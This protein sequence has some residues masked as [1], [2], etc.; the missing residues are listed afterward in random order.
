MQL[1]AGSSKQFVE[2]AMQDRITEKLE[3]AFSQHFGR[4][5]ARSEARAWENSL[6]RMGIVLKDAGLLDHGVILEY[7]LGLTSRRLD[8]M[9]TGT[10]GNRRPSAV[11]IELKQWD[12][13]E[14]SDAKDNVFVLTRLGGS[15]REV[16]HPSSQVEGYQEFLE[17]NHA[18]FSA[19]RVSLA[20]CCYLHNLQYSAGNGLFDTRY[21]AILRSHPVFTRGQGI[22][23][24]N[25]LADRM[26]TGDGAGI[27][28]TV[29]EGGFKAS[30]KLL[31]HVKSMIEGKKEF[32]LLDEQK[33]VFNRV[34]R[35]A[36]IGS[37]RKGRVVILAKGGPGTGK[38]VIALNLV[39]ALSG[40]GLNTQYA[41]GSKAFTENLRDL[42][43]RKAGIQLKYFSDYMSAGKD[44]VDV[45][46]CDEAHRLWE[47]GNTRWTRKTERSDRPLVEHVIEAAKVTAFFIDDLQVVRPDEVGNSE[48]IRRAAK[49]LNAT[50]Y[51]FDLEAQF[52]VAGSE[53]FINWVDN[54]LGVRRA[55]DDAWDAEDFDFRIVDSV[56]ELEAMIR[57]KHGAG[58]KARLTAGF[59]WPWSYPDSDGHLIPDVRIG[60][61]TRPWNARS[62][63]KLAPGI[64]CTSLWATDPNG[65]DQVGC[66]YTAQGFEF[67]YVGVIFGEDLRYDP[68]SKTWVGDRT[69]SFDKMGARRAKIDQEFLDLVKN[70]YRVLLTRGM[71][72]CY[73]Y[74]MDEDTRNFFN[75][76][77]PRQT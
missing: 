25:F 38:S 54:T 24:G 39:A 6:L 51:E 62:G 33:A 64:P 48:L 44:V 40:A 50:V 46:V 75:S 59:C 4:E 15:T 60:D 1:Y 8:F 10:D 31:D 45:L 37:R 57:G 28:E 29:L 53:G 56:Q 43:G 67:D 19:G 34:L 71:K 3:Q 17:Y 18:S 76:R 41:T 22:A 49:D 70:T 77:L 20:S 9:I 16:L 36:R 72:G 58:S 12:N 35:E 69:R 5:V 65:I 13:A 21:D 47:T 66:I 74:F 14:A 7:K 23:L 63:R 73:V 11:I 68:E 52:R 32:V 30:R 55:D 27:M 42:L 26:G 61:W 2:D